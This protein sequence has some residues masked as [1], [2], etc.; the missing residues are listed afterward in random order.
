MSER[1][2]LSELAGFCNEPTAWRILKD[3]SQQLI[4]HDP[5]IVTP[6]LIEIAGDGHFALTP[7]DAHQLGYDAPNAQADTLTEADAVWSLGATIFFI[8]M[9]RQ[10]MNGKGG[11][12]QTAVSK[13]PYM[14][15]EWPEMSELVKR[16][17][18]YEPML[19]PSLQEVFDT[20]EQQDKRS[21][22]DIKRGPK[23]KKATPNSDP[24]NGLDSSLA[25]WPENMQSSSNNP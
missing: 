16:C 8:V 9:G 15:S 18:Q 13:L 11:K 25:F 7:S 12:G 3:V 5:C 21:Q 20:A 19:R 2:H 14:R 24:G 6:S 4:E 10:V 1:T 22:A 23:F 17:L